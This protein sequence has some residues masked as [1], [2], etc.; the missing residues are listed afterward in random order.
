MI[1]NVNLADSIRKQLPAELVRFMQKA[2]E[3]AGRSGIKLYLVGG[4]VRDLILQRP[5]LDLDLVAEGDAIKL[6]EELAKLEN[7]RVVAHSR[8]NTAKIK[9]DK[10]S[11]DIAASRAEGYKSPGALPNVQPSDIQ[12]DLIRRDFTI[13]AMA[14]F[15]DPPQYGELL[16]LYK[17][18]I[19]LE[20]KLVRILH[21]NSFEDDAT[22]IWRAVRY[23]E[24]LDFTI[25]PHTLSLLKRDI[26]YLDTISGDRIRH[27]LELVL[28]EERPEKA[29]MRA[30]ELGVLARICP[31][32]EA[33]EWV[34]KR[35]ARA[36]GMLQPYCP[37]KEMY[38]S[39]LIY[40]LAP[41]DLEDLIIYLKLTRPIAQT[42]RD[43]LKLKE[44]LPSLGEAEIAPSQ[45][46]RCLHPYSQPAVLANLMATDFPLVRQNIEFFL[47]KL[48]HIQPALTG[49]D[50]KN[51]GIASGPQIHEI[52]DS[53][54]KARLDG[55]VTTR[56]E[57]LEM[58]QRFPVRHQK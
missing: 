26:T 15:L 27:E 43:T 11:V 39:F 44:G 1:K 52:L 32:L 6:A 8:F 14:V 48:R 38:L 13:N 16:D 28:E 55:K 20:H 46:Y 54:R 19:D 45:I 53:L 37:P 3:V 25:E 41:A 30:D 5:N 33:G 42:L 24:R 56:N 57:E 18:R 50:L 47:N 35:I 9:W 29:L 2:G 10:W 34:A 31:R 17:G 4:V 36:R 7:G 51:M 22:R 12:S 40:R 49:E 21:D 58:V 23:E